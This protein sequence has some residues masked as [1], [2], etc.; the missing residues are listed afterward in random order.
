MF[1]VATSSDEL[2]SEE[3]E[4]SLVSVFT[5]S[6]N[7]GMVRGHKAKATSSDLVNPFGVQ[8]LG[9]ILPVKHRHVSEP[10]CYKIT[11]PS[12]K[13]Y[14]GQT[15]WF[16][17]RMSRHRNDHISGCRALSNAIAKYGWEQLKVEVLWKG[18]RSEMNAM[19]AQLIEIHGTLA[20]DG[21]NL[22]PGGG[23]NPAYDASVQAKL[24]GMRDSGEMRRRMQAGWAKRKEAQTSKRQPR[25]K[26]D[27]RAE[28]YPR[29][30][31]V[32]DKIKGTWE[33]KR[34]AKW[35]AMGLS[36]EDKETRRHNCAMQAAN[37]KRKRTGL[38]PD[39][40]SIGPA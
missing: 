14:I 25:S 7:E 17:Q 27:P 5:N 9:G 22:V 36:E 15:L 33:R 1:L 12:T 23:Y 37:K 13:A 32:I 24:K 38:N 10:C 20:P 11:S 30:A 29:P 26:W 3:C 16:T 31:T 28:R 39:D 6:R 2:D 35:E 19:E 34:E 21:Y 40:H 18:P 4:H 8:V